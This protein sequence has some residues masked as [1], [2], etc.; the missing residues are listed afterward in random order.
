LFE[1]IVD[2]SVRERNN[3]AWFSVHRQLLQARL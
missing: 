3:L 2:L 1:L